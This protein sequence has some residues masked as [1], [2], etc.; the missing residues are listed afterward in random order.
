M[1]FSDD[2]RAFGN[3]RE[4]ISRRSAEEMTDALKASGHGCRLITPA[5]AAYSR[6][7]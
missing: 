2:R 1:V 3:A 7:P 6:F 5:Q 4:N